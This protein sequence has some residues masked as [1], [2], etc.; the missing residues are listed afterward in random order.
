M[1]YTAT[2]GD[3]AGQGAWTRLHDAGMFGRGITIHLGTG[4]D[5]GTIDSVRGGAIASSPF[6]ATVTTVYA[7]RGRRRHHGRRTRPSRPR[8][9]SSTATTATTRSTRGTSSLPVV[10]VRRRRAPTRSPA[11]RATTS[12]SAT[13]AASTTSSRRPP[14]AST[15]CSAATRTAA[16]LP[17]VLDAVFLTP[18]LLLT[19]DTTIGTGDT[20]DAGTRQRH[21][22]RRRGS[23][24]A[25]TAT[26]ATT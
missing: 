12:S 16:L 6:G 20:I 13:T 15:S 10:A 26:A 2:G 8:C 1:T 21:R 7:Q 18:D 25:S 24:H 3:L 11:A 14:R 4:S 9:S 19:R 5:S 23:R 22:A 17:A